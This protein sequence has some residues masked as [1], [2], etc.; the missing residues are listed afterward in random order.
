MCQ[1]TGS[2]SMGWMLS[3]GR[4]TGVCRW[5]ALSLYGGCGG[6]RSSIC[7]SDLCG[8]FVRVGKVLPRSLLAAHPDPSGGPCPEDLCEPLWQRTCGVK[9]VAVSAWIWISLLCL[10]S[11]YSEKWIFCLEQTCGEKGTFVQKET[12]LADMCRFP[13]AIEE[14]FSAVLL[15]A[16][17]PYGSV[18]PPR[19][20]V[21]HGNS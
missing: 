2:G 16:C 14:L 8:R 4:K 12:F 9:K 3:R 15:F 1:H 5:Q 19:A 11:T 18:S 13:H 6:Y 17:F 10:A 21:C 20:Q 7:I